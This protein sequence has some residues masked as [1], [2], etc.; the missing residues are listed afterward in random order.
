VRGRV[1]CRRF[2]RDYLS[3]IP[4]CYL[5]G[6]QAY[7][8]EG[9]Y[10]WIAGR[11]DDVIK[12]SG[13]RIGTQEVE[14]ALISHDAVSETAVV[15]VPDDIKGQA[16]YAFVTLKSG[17]TGSDELK[18]ELIQVVRKEIGAIAA[19]AD[20]QWAEGLPKTRS[21]KIMRRLLRKIASGQTEELGDISTLA[22]P[23]VVEQLIAGM[24]A[25]SITK[26]NKNS[27]G[28]TLLEL[29]LVIMVIGI[30]AAVTVTPKWTGTA[31]QAEYETRHI[32]SDIRFAQAMS[33]ATGERYR[34]V[35]TSS[36]TYQITDEAG[37]AVLL[38]N[39]NTTMTLSGAVTLGA[40]TN[41][42]NNLIA[43]D[44]RGT[45]YTDT[46]SPG[47]ALAATATIPVTNSSQTRNI[48][49]TPTTGYGIEQ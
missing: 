42:P 48:L 33:M 9:G 16:I 34:W 30:L 44:S 39:G 20:I 5:T 1:S 3:E 7:R 47:T 10:F 18:N 24:H 29:L 43:F 11:S 45:P 6:D 2:I 49:I 41:L 32:L 36:N 38:P 12:V 4:G 17:R 27:Q 40:F 22:D 19:P 23:D 35:R 37:V 14:S 26:S 21:G 13:H 28:F 46:T 15:P 31:L 8:D 25:L